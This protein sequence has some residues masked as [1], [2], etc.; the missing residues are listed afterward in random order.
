[1][2]YTKI[3][4]VA[5]LWALSFSRAPAQ[6][7]GFEL[8]KT[9][10]NTEALGLGEATTAYLLGASGLYTNPAN[11][12]FENSSGFTADYTLWIGG[13]TNTHAA[14]NFKRDRSAIAFGLLASDAGD[15]ELRNRPGPSQGSFSVSYLSLAGGYAYGYHNFAIG[16]SFQYLREEL[17]IY[18]ASGYSFNAGISS[19]W[20]NRRLYVSAALQNAGKMDKLNTE[21]T[22]LPTLF[23][24]GINARLFEITAGESDFP[25]TFS[26]LSDLVMPVHD[27]ETSNSNSSNTLE[28]ESAYLNIGISVTAAEIITLRG[29]YKTGETVR[30]LSFGTGILFNNV[31]A[32]YAIVPFE[33]GFGTVHSIGIGYRF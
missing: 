14:I 16:A 31:S 24:G 1:M 20:L 5:L 26:L 21:E 3:F 27:T 7:T 2:S 28:Q 13:L 18:N 4:I 9:G 11:L 22:R 30:P 8:L 29:G 19:H 12:A 15:F 32:N 10:P 25:I 33:T 6:G 23:R 17:Y